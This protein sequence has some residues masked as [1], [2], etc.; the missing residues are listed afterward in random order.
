MQRN[1]GR[2]TKAQRTNK[3]RNND[4]VRYNAPTTARRRESIALNKFWS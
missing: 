3:W 4:D 1:A 2:R